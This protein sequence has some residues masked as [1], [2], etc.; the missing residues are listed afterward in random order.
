MANGGKHASRAKR[1][2]LGC[3]VAR[4]AL[5]IFRQ[6]PGLLHRELRRRLTRPA[7]VRRLILASAAPQGAAGMHGWAPDV[8]GAV[9][10]P[11]TSPGAYLD[12]FFAHSPSSSAAGQQA[13]KRMYART[14]DR[15]KPTSWQTRLAQYD[16]VRTWGIPITDCWSG[17]GRLTSRSSWPTGTATP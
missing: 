16:A 10:T 3:N 2:R 9:G 4:S 15:D 14:E 5:K 13:L 17:C 1:E 11:Q 12:V 7:I 8:I 6:L